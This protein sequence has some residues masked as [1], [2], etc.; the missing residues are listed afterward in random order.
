MSAALEA[1][2]L[3]RVYASEEG[4]AAALQGL[5]LEIA[6][7]EIAVVFGPS[8]SGKTTF[9][10][11]AAGLDRPSAGRIRVL[12]VDLRRLSGRRLDE[13]RANLIGYADQYY[14]RVL[15]PELTVRSLVELPLA[16]AGEPRRVRRARAAE[17]LERVGL[18]ERADARPNE[19]SGGEQQR[20]ALCAAVAR[21]PRLLL[22]D[23]PTGELDSESAS[24]VYALIHDLV[25]RESTAAVIVSHDVAST[26][27]AD[28]IV[29]I[30]D[31]RVSGETVQDGSSDSDS[32]VVAR[33]GWIHL[34]EELLRRARIQRRARAALV[35]GEILLASADGVHEREEIVEGDRPV[36]NRPARPVGGVVAELRAVERTFGS[37]AAATVA[38][39]RL[40]RQFPRGGFVAIAGPSGSGKTTLLHLLSGLD[41]PT[42]GEVVVLGT[43]IS[44]LDRAARAAFRREQL[45]LVAQ[46]AP[47]VPFLS[48]REN[49]TLALGVRGFSRRE[50]ASSAD[51]ALRAIAMGELAD[52]RVARLSLGERQRVAIARAAAARPQLLLAD[53]PSARLDQA[54]ALA[55]AELL[56]RLVDES[57]TSVIYATH[58]PVLIDLADETLEL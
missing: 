52:Q 12:G 56:A 8:G 41:V 50:A 26:T 27:I 1:R 19:L 24:E 36:P 7:G 13:F 4:A 38:L 49:V 57:G 34:P 20:V 2:D 15:A 40:T 35:D 32:I 29:Q 22:A 58:D 23:E 14:S 54:N 43:A 16:L 30:R 48:A 37:G 10:R 25:R 44:R 17:L 18:L 9:L 33:G 47:L 6:A 28:R 31:G 42:D 51:D 46:D 11:A 45:A 5:S 21:R 3:F 39:K 55:V 53:E